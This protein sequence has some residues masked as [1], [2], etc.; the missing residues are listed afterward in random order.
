MTTMM[1]EEHC[2]VIMMMIMMMMLMMLRLILRLSLRLWW[3]QDNGC[4]SS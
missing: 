3:C 2:D 1:V 4:L